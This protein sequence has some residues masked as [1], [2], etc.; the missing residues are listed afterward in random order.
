MIE[1]KADQDAHIFIVFNDG[2]FS[3]QCMQLRLDFY[4]G[5]CREYN[6]GTFVGEQRRVVRL[7][8]SRGEVFVSRPLA[9]ALVD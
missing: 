7:G 4:F 1:L 9:H 3:D 6:G 8:I 5:S 2:V